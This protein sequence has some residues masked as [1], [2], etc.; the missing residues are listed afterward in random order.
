MRKR[1]VREKKIYCGDKYLEVDILPYT[2]NQ[3]RRS[4]KRSKKEKVTP[5]PQRNLNDK[6]ARRYITQTANANF[7]KG[8]L[9]VTVTYKPKYLPK[10]EADAGRE[11]ANYI[12]R[13][14]HR[15]KREGL[16][17]GKYICVTEYGNNGRIHHH[18]I[19]D[20]GLDRDV[21]EGLWRR[22]RK[23]GELE[24]ERIGY[25]NADRLQPDENGVAALAKY[26]TKNPGGKKRWSCSQNLIRPWSRTNDSKYGIRQ[27]ERLANAPP[28]PEH[29]EKKY[30][31]Y[32]ITN[33]AYGIRAEYY[34]QTGW[35]IYLQLWK[36]ESRKE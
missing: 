11:K 1:F 21:V 6:N 27:V 2:E 3:M 33:G 8:D 29:W 26:I 14:N 4:G 35:H 34:D 9:H 10:T 15:R 24:G 19:M 5:P 32:R 22:R 20:G 25:A 12:R 18:I 23:K 36:T 28:N 16:P 31:G 7:G 17:P 13:I 30:P